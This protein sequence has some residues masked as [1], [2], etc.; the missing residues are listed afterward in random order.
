MSRVRARSRRR[1]TYLPPCRGWS[2]A[3]TSSARSRRAHRRS[4]SPGKRSTPPPRSRSRSSGVRPPRSSSSTPS[5]AWTSRT[6]SA[7]G[8]RRDGDGR[9]RLR[10]RRDRLPGRRRPRRAL[11]HPGRGPDRPERLHR[12]LRRR[13]RRGP[14]H[15]RARGLRA[16]L[17]PPQATTGP[18]SRRGALGRSPAQVG[19]DRLRDAARVAADPVHHR[20]R[21]GVEE[22]E[23]GEVE[24]RQALGRAAMAR[25]RPRCDGHPDGRRGQASRSRRSSS[26]R[27]ERRSGASRTTTTRSP[28]AR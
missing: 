18:R 24:A 6:T 9:A 4:R 20:R 3:P 5:R 26:E 25:L 7:T 13:R 11:R 1:S 15:G 14:H 8:R 2:P 17:P 23:T 12:L 28:R 10:H 16:V 27:N 22:L 21:L 19:R